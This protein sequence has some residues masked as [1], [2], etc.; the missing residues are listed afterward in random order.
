VKSIDFFHVNQAIS[1]ELFHNAAIVSEEEIM[2]QNVRSMKRGT[3]VAVIA[4]A[5]CFTMYG[6][7]GEPVPK[8]ASSPGVT[9]NPKVSPFISNSGEMDYFPGELFSE[10][11]A[12]ATK[13]IHYRNIAEGFSDISS[14]NWAFVAAGGAHTV[15]VK[16][17]GTLWAWGCND[18]GRLGDG[19]TVDRNT[20]TQIGTESSKVFVT[21]EGPHTVS[22]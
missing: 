21:A 17:D 2:E 18:H 8:E 14:N 5:V 10:Q 20:P 9:I 22:L 13:D 16:A 6:G 7:S 1:C 15:A 3:V 11:T 19:T 4:M 12:D